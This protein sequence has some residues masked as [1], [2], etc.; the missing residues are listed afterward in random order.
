[1]KK[2]QSPEKSKFTS[3]F[4][5]IFEVLRNILLNPFQRIWNQHKIMHF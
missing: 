3:F 2:I 1:M 5:F 4:D